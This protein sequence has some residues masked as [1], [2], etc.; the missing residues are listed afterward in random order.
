MQRPILG[1]LFMISEFDIE[2]LVFP[3][4][5]IKGLAQ[6]QSAL[7]VHDWDFGNFIEGVIPPKYQKYKKRYMWV[8]RGIFG[9]ICDMCFRSVGS[10]KPYTCSWGQFWGV[11]AYSSCWIG[12][13]IFNIWYWLISSHF[14][15]HFWVISELFYCCNLF[16]H[17]YVE[18]LLEKIKGTPQHH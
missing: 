11:F 9:S 8:V 5:K 3:W 1:M 16:L 12:L 6:P 10:P 18:G 7:K 15:H 14:W 4:V 13:P 2:T 17:F